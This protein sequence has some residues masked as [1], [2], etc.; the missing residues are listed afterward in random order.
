[1]PGAPEPARPP[2]RAARPPAVPP[3]VWVATTYFA[4]GLPFTIIRQLST[5]FFTRVGASE[6]HL[7]YL[8][9]LGIPWNL[10]LLW[11]P[12]VDAVGTKRRWLLVTEL[13]LAAG[14]LAIAALAAAMARDNAA[15]APG[16]L[17]E[18]AAVLVVM[19]F[20]SATHDVA[21]DG[22]YLEGLT[23]P[24]IQA[25]YTG[26][27]V[28]AYRIAIV[29]VRS[30][31]GGLAGWLEGRRAVPPAG[32]SALEVAGPWAWAFA[33]GAASLALLC[34]FHALCLPRF[35]DSSRPR[36]PPR[37]IAAAFGRAFSTFLSQERAGVSLL[38]IATYKLGDDLLFSMSTPF[39]GR[40]LQVSDADLAWIAGVVGAVSASL[41]VIA[42]GAWIHRRGLKRA[43]WP[44][45]L[46]MN[47]NIW[48]YVGLAALHPD[49]RTPAGL[50]AIAAVHGYEQ[51]AAGLGNAVLVV[52]L[53]R[54][55][56]PEFKA[57]H[58][59][60][61]SAI[62]SLGSTVLG[63]W[64]GVFVARFGY[65]RLFEAS[66]LVTLPAM[67]LLF[68]VPIRGDEANQDR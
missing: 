23:D 21:I 62:M 47:L 33:A 17:R 7:G 66:F 9:F 41:G 61:G 12:L 11:S 60:I 10:K 22:Y 31:L 3:A 65:L 63:G 32:G 13:L 1:M 44:L 5:V 36:P 6:R 19:A 38:F 20:V 18:I 29:F 8:N 58:Y 46:L 30:G 54:T 43:I 53:L 25:R 14:T 42:G 2:T 16:H 28:T 40:E 45:T 67:A 57:A 68:V 59:A 26:F 35:E 37:A 49:A 50:A 64:A 39:L 34:A 52:F 15:A 56:L 24:R 48:A 27:R 55:C 51:L 4:E